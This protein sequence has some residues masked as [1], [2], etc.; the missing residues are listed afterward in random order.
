MSVLSQ[1]TIKSRFVISPS[2]G[3]RVCLFFLLRLWSGFLVLVWHFT[4]LYSSCFNV[5][6]DVPCLSNLSQKL[7][8]N[9]SL[10]LPSSSCRFTRSR[11]MPVWRASGTGLVQ[12]S[13]LKINTLSI[14][15]DTKTEHWVQRESE[16]IDRE[17][18]WCIKQWVNETILHP[19]K[20][21]KFHLKSK[22]NKINQ[23]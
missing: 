4:D 18:Q 1:S 6:A 16:Q 9:V 14:C 22:V 20:Q 12:L 3:I 11:F 23:N 15:I 7:L 8:L 2:A 10:R 19:T 17:W 13:T 21:K 5:V